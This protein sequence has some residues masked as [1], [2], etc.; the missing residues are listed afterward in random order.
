MLRG[1]LCQ[2]EFQS[3]IIALRWNRRRAGRST[4][5]IGDSVQEVK[6]L[7]VGGVDTLA[8]VDDDE[9]LADSRVDQCRVFNHM[10]EAPAIIASFERQRGRD[11]VVNTRGVFMLFIGL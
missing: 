2:A 5:G 7:I 3:V 1:S 10:V 9:S 8:G 4:V 6:E 11:L